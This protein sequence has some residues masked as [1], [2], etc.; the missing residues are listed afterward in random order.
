VNLDEATLRGARQTDRQLAP[1]SPFSR[2]AASVYLPMLE[3]N[4]CAEA[5]IE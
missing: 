4:F 3:A 5:L 1:R 2:L